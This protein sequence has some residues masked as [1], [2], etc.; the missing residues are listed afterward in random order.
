MGKV[1]KAGSL[2]DVIKQFCR[3]TTSMKIHY[4]I[5]V[6]KISLYIST[7]DHFI[8][9]YPYA[10]TLTI[11]IWIKAG[12]YYCKGAGAGRNNKEE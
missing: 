3:R 1:R 8:I 4:Y 10:A 9:D 6:R 11:V 7:V 2:L 5:Q 12:D